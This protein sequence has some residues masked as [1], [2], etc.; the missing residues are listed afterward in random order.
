MRKGYAS[1]A[2][3]PSNILDRLNSGV[4][5]SVTLTE[6]LAIDQ[7][8]LWQSVV[9]DLPFPQDY[10]AS[11]GIVK[12]MRQL[13]AALSAHADDPRL[14][15]CDTSRGWLCFAHDTATKTLAD[16][17]TRVKPF[18]QDSHFGVR[19]WAWLAIRDRIVAEP[20]LAL[21]LLQTWISDEDESVRRFASEATR[22]R[23]V[24]CAQID[25]FKKQPELAIS[26]LE[27]LRSDKSK[28]VRL[29]VANWLNDASKTRPEWVLEV[30][31]RWQIESP[32]KET[33]EIIKRAL[34]TIEKERAK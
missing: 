12:K 19:E 18:A 29:S 3:I 25:L 17:M 11:L 8:R 32:T 31:Q 14:I 6:C 23:G 10:D 4:E 33:Q 30:A 15:R 22:P 26:L 7:A 2:A 13:G 20:L 27:P 24:W 28:Y 5:D 9:P 16:A 34:R 1:I 21:E